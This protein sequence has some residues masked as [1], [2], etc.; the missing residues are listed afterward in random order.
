METERRTQIA[1]WDAPRPEVKGKSR[2]LRPRRISTE[3]GGKPRTVLSPRR[4]ESQPCPLLHR[5][6]VSSIWPRPAGC[7]LL[8]TFPEVALP[9][10]SP[11]RRLHAGPQ[12]RTGS[13]PHS[14]LEFGIRCI[15]F[16]RTFITCGQR[17]WKQFGLLMT[18][19][20][21]LFL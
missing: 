11:D 10:C 20:S 18:M 5:P 16:C 19:I 6:A 1:P 14:G 21:V 13:C 17:K 2:I 8:P 15:R 3:E 4:R 12:L 7:F 9:S